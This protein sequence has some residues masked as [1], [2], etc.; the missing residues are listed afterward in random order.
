M[1]VVAREQIALGL[2]RT[3]ADLGKVTLKRDA[4]QARIGLERHLDDFGLPVR[5]GCKIDHARTGRTGREV[6]LAVADDGR[7]E[8]TLHHV[9]TARTVAVDHI[10]DGALVVFLEDGDV[11]DILPDKHLV[12]HTHQLVFAVAVEDEHVVDVRTVGDELVLLQARADETLFAVDVEL[13]RW[14]PPLWW[15]RWC[16]S[17]VSP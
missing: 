4:S 10:V 11:E 17:C 5:I 14:P 16:R 12:G 6:I 2:T 7:H 15:L 8:E 1:H 3:D 9:S 13:F